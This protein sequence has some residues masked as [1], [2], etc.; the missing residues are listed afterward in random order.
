[1]YATQILNE[2]LVFTQALSLTSEA[3]RGSREFRSSYIVAVTSAAD[4]HIVYCRV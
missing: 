1:M 4:L 3:R 2:A